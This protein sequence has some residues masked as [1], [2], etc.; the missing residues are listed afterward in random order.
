MRDAGGSS[1]RELPPTSAAGLMSLSTAASASEAPAGGWGNTS[2][3]ILSAVLK[4]EMMMPCRSVF[5]RRTQEAAHG[6]P[7]AGAGAGR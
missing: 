4:S 2:R 5:L 3:L 7:G 1:S 6:G